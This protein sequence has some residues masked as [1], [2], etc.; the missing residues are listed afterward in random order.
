[1]IVLYILLG[2]AAL[3]LV[4]VFG[5]A[6]VA[7]KVIFSRG[8]GTEFD[9]AIA[10]EGDF[11]CYAEQLRAGR[12]LL[13]AEG[14]R[15]VSVS[16]ED[17]LRLAADYRDAHS[18]YTAILLHGYHSDPMLNVSVQGAC[19][20]KRGY[21]ILIPDQRAHGRSGGE[22]TGLG[23]LEQEDLLTWTRWLLAETSTRRIV[24]YGVSMGAATTAYASD[25]LDPQTVAAIVLDCG[26]DSPDSQIR[27]EC[28]KRHLPPFL[29]MPVIRLLAKRRLGRDIRCSVHDSL[30]R[31]TIPAYFLHGTRDQTVL[32]TEGR[33]AFEACAS[34]KSFYSVAGVGHAAAFLKD[35][36]RAEEALFAFLEEV[37]PSAGRP[38]ISVNQTNQA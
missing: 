5:P 21:N 24:V 19:F 31:T 9:R 8:T 28:V 6:A 3:Y 1:M 26:F 32:W 29:M 23:I 30:S 15:E 37:D 36:E 10:P 33:A 12:D 2:L 14:L 7:S 34:K 4:F 18:A 38:H 22:R 11:A 20:A 25:R 27:R 16:S 17:G 13:Y 35:P